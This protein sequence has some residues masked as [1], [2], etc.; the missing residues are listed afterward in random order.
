MLNE[1]KFR[2]YK[3]AKKAERLADIDKALLH[4]INRK[5]AVERKRTAEM[6]AERKK[7]DSR[8]EWSASRP[9]ATQAKG[10]IARAERIDKQAVKPSKCVSILGERG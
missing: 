6:L 3:A 9:S 5:N 1:R 2:R 10:K 7:Y 4:E 8:K